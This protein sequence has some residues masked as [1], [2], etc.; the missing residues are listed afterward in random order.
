MAALLEPAVRPRTRVAGMLRPRLRTTPSRLRLAVAAIVVAALAFGVLGET[1]AT[2][3]RDAARTAATESEPLLVR[4]VRL[5]DALA[6]ADATA[7]ATFVIGG[8]EP[9]K[10]RQRY[11][12]DVTSASSALAVLGRRTDTSPETAAAVATIGRELPLYTGLIETA[13]ADNR[14]GFPVGAAYLRQA[15]TLMRERILPAAAQVY[16]VEGRRL[17]SRYREGSSAGPVIAFA[18]VAV[19]TLAVLIAVQAYLTRLTHRRLN[20]PLV[21][22]TLMFGAVAAW[23]LLGLA[24]EQRALL[25]A[26]R[27][28]SDPVEVLSAV[29]VLALR[30]QADEGL[31]LAARGSGDASL[32]DFAAAMQMLGV[33][34]ASD[35]LLSDARAFADRQGSAADIRGLSEQFHAYQRIHERVVG[36]AS[37]G[38]FTAAADLSVGPSG[39]ELVLAD[40]I[41]RRLDRLITASQRRFEAA[42]ADASSAVNGLWVAI[43]LLT[44]AG[45]L[46]AL[47][48]VRLRLNEYR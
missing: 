11:L 32:A 10:R 15:S 2:T 22:A 7:S 30:A 47:F 6:D 13:R 17:N 37:E 26:Q 14:Q 43:P 40:A 3:R 42:A 4:A 27:D 24:A 33:S 12:T 5:H 39:R 21:A 16:A 34:G 35:G 8:A 29:R 41:R 23:G 20:V 25:R 36:L 38:R 46:L 18:L 45:A 19:L 44:C 28:G 1:A 31:S 48:G 9:S